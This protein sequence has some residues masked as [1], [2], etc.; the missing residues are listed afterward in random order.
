MRDVYVVDV[1]TPLDEVLSH[2]AET[3]VGSALVVKNGKLAGI[4]TNGDVCRV[5]ADLL[6]QRFPAPEEDIS[7]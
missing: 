4:L 5:L 6:R 1:D 3:H 7:A 2:I